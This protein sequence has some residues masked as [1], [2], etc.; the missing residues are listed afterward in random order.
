MPAFRK[1]ECGAAELASTLIICIH[2]LGMEMMY[3]LAEAANEFIAKLPPAAEMEEEEDNNTN[4]TV[5]AG[6]SGMA[7]AEEP[8][9][10]DHMPLIIAVCV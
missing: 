7:G 9:G 5:D 2:S 3:Q 6:A 8:E 4:S 10:F 1:S